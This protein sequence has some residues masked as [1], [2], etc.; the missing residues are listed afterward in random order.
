MM[1]KFLNGLV[2]GAGFAISLVIIWYVGVFVITPKI[3]SKNINHIEN[4]TKLTTIAPSFKENSGYLGSTGSYS[5]GFHMDRSNILSTG[6][7]IIRGKILINGIPAEG[8]KIRLALNNKVLSQWAITNSIGEYIIKVPYG[9]YRIDGYELD[10]AV[11]D[12]KLNGK[13]D[14]PQNPHSGA[15]QYIDKENEGFGLNLKFVDPVIKKTKKKYLLSDDVIL[16]W[17]PYPNASKY[18]IQLFEKNNPYTWSNKTVFA[19]SKMPSVVEPKINLTALGVHLK[20][21]HFYVLQ[22]YA[23]DKNDS[24][25]SESN[26]DYNGFDF[27]VK[28]K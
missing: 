19:H 26:R 16:E 8:V 15:V 21:D 20:P 10:K 25:L 11:A 24:L 3:L 4:N 5:S 1:K 13:I 18:S 17:E 12:I 7:G 2:F 22:V 14:H 27:T 9:K 28:N 23:K 6:P